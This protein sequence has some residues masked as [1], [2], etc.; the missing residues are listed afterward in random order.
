MNDK[1]VKIK[2]QLDFANIRTFSVKDRHNLVTIANMAKPDIDEVSEWGNENFEELVDRIVE[3]RRNERPVIWSMGA[4]VIKNGMS[5]YIIELVKRGLVT[6]ISS[7]GAGSI[8]DF[9]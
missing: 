2:G 6:H 5:R 3:A 4:H 9:E 1:N 8:H 7:N